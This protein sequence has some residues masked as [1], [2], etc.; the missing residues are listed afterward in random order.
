MNE[1]TEDAEIYWPSFFDERNQK[2]SLLMQPVH[3]L[4]MEKSMV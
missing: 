1:T 3:M 4:P 2:F